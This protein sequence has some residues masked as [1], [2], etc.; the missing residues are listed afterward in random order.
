M[1]D[2][3]IGS[4]DENGWL[5][6]AGPGEEFVRLLIRISTGGESADDGDEIGLW[7]GKGCARGEVGDAGDVE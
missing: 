6:A 5:L 4:G 1:F 7:N 2:R 3:G